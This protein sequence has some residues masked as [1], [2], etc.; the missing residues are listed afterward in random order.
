MS[1]ENLR[2]ESQLRFVASKEEIEVGDADQCPLP[3][4]TML[5]IY[6]LVISLWTVFFW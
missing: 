5:E 6:V 4:T 2:H 3:V 1:K